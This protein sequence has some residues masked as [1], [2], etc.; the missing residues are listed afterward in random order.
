MCYARMIAVTIGFYNKWI[1][2][3]CT[4]EG[5]LISNHFKYMALKEGAIFVQMLILLPLNTMQLCK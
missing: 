5:P 1:V 3:F 4:L 2:A